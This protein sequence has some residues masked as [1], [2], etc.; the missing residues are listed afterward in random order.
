VSEP[1]VRL[2]A[3]QGASQRPTELADARTCHFPPEAR[4]GADC[5]AF[6][7]ERVVDLPHFAIFGIACLLVL[8]GAWIPAILLFLVDVPLRETSIYLVPLILAVGYS[9]NRAKKAAV[10]AAAM[11]AVWYPYAS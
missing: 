7:E 3:K 4:D 9:Q 10:M 5:N 6:I 8:E 2:S 1:R 11:V